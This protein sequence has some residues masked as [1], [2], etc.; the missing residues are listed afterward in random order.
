ML[1]KVAPPG[2]IIAVVNVVAVPPSESTN[3]SPVGRLPVKRSPGV[4]VV[5][6][7]ELTIP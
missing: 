4:N 6:A 5:V 2:E 1:L 7:P 3:K